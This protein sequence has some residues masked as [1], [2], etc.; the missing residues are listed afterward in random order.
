MTRHPY[1]LMTTMKQPKAYYDAKSSNARIV[2]LQGGTRSGKTWSVLTLLCEWCY[3]Y[4]N[5]GYTID[6]VRAAFP[7]LRASVYRDFVTILEREGWYDPRNH[8]KTEH[9]YNLFGNLWRFYSVESGG[10]K[11]RGAKRNFLFLNEAN[12]L[13]KEVFLQLAFRCTEKLFIDFNP[14]MEF[15]W[16]YD[17]VIPRDDCDFFQSTY[18]DNPYL[19]AETIAEI[20][21]LKETDADYWRVYGLGERGKSRAT[22]FES[23]IYEEVPEG[24]KLVAYGLDWG[25][26]S[27]PTALV[28]VMRK[29]TDLYIQEL[30]YQGGLTNADIIDRL[31]QLEVGRRD[32]IVADSAEP[33]S[34]EEIRRAGYLIKPSIKGPDSIRKGIDL[35]R[36]HKLHLKAD[37]M[38]AQKEFRNYKWKTDRDNRTIPVPEDDWNHCVDSVRYVCLNKLLRRTGTYIMQ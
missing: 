31:K 16:I 33:K 29:G 30:L 1:S 18:L 8:N 28:K 36:R 6:V 10:E 11:V 4:R 34:I 26:S 25:F 22:I 19:N 37:S 2:C 3:R 38:N 5:A 21:R 12:E 24:A 23:H 15:H 14:S 9:T 17:E 7:S 27:D 20:E 35:M 32:E 13:T